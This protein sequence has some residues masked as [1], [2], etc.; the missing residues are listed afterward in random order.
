MKIALF[1]ADFTLGGAER[2]FSDLAR[3]FSERGH[4]VELVIGNTDNAVYLDLIPD[5]VCV[6]NLKV[7][8]MRRSLP[9]LIGYLHKNKPDIVLATRADSCPFVVLA[10]IFSKVKTAIVLREANTL[11]SDLSKYRGGKRLLLSLF[12]K[13]LYPLAD[14]IVG[15][16]EGVKEDLKKFLKIKGGKL[17]TIYSP[18]VTE[19]LFINASK[20]CDH[21]WLQNKDIPV[22]LSVG[23]LAFQKRFDLLIKAFAIVRQ[24]RNARLL[25]LGEGEERLQLESLAADLKLREDINLAG[26]EPNPFKYMS[27]ANLFV[28]SSDWEGLPGAL[29]QALACGCPV[30][31]TDCPSGPREILKNGRLGRLIPMGDVKAMAAAIEEA[32]N[33]KPL[34]VKKEELCEYAAGK[35][36][37][38]YLRVFEAVKKK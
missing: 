35:S 15:V 9:A 36:I 24:Q 29:V 20:P 38:N 37:D 4:D 2:V 17:C 21:P 28:L 12:I 1:I 23:R 14:M 16:S 19:E 7:K 26:F 27:R 32:L 13:T 10:K 6:V 18:I 30:I 11:S 22:I 5:N 25:I 8:R 33:Q 3:G 34:R 31:S